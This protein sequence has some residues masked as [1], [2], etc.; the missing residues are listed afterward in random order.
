MFGSGTAVSILPIKALGYKEQIYRINV[1]PKLSAG[2]LTHAI[3][4]KIISI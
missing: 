1:N 3:Y 2:D 4:E